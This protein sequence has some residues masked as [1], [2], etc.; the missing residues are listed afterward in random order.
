MRVYWSL[1]REQL[2][3]LAGGVDLVLTGQP[4]TAV[5]TGFADTVSTQDDDELD[6]LAALSS[7][8]VNDNCGVIA[9]LDVEAEVTDDALGEVSFSADVAVTD[10]G[11]FM[12]ADIDAQELSW[13]GIQEI[14]EVVTMVGMK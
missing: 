3:A 1:T 2:L 11:C 13:Y 12:I 10:I 7:L 8:D 9:A 5:T 14:D 4:A 6:L